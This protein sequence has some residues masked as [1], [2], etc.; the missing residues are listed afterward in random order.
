MCGLA[1]E[2]VSAGAPDMAALGRM[3]AVLAP[4]G[5]DSMGSWRQGRVGLVHRRLKVIDL[6][7][8]GAQPMVDEG[9][10]LAI[11]FN[12]C[13]YNYRELRAELIAAGQT[14]GSRS[15]TEVILAAYQHWGPERF[16]EHLIGMFA[17][18]LVE[19]SPGGLVTLGRDRLG[20][21]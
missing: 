5:P 4:R 19:T 17:F 1:G 8:R 15:D 6:S 11:V 16:V 18:A 9:R 20:I 14:F 21:N 7:D 13:I 12:G 3:S 10:Q 2:I